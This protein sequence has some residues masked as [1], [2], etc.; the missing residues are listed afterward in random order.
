MKFKILPVI[1]F[2][3]S[4]YTLR[5]QNNYAVKGSVTDSASTGKMTNTT[6]CILNAKDSTL[7]KY[8]R[9]SNTGAFAINNLRKGNYILMVT[10]PDYADYIELFHLDSVKTQI[11]FGRI[12]MTLKS[13]IL[14]EV[15]IKGSK[16]QIKIKGDTTEFNAA[17][18]V[19]QPNSKVEDLLKQL[20]GIQVDKDG[21][22]TAQG[23]TVNKVLVDGEE[24]FGDDPTLVTKNIRAD[25]VDKVQLYDKKSDQAAFTGI[26]DGVKNKT[27]NIKL[28]EDKKTGYFGKVDA[29]IATD[30][31]YQGQL[32]FNKFTAKQKFSLYTTDANTGKTGLGWQ[33]ASKY[34]TSSDNVQMIDGGVMIMNNGRGDELEAFNGQY[35]GQGIPSARTGGLHYDTR[36]NADKE[37]LN[38]N[39]KI[40]YLGVDGTNESLSQYSLPTSTQ[41]Y[42]SAESYHKTIFRQKLD[43]TLQIKIDTAS[44]LKISIDGTIKHTQTNSDFTFSTYQDIATL[45]NQGLRTITNTGDAKIFNASAFYTKKFSK[46]GRTLSLNVTE[47]I[48]QNDTKGYL[49]SDTHYYATSGNTDSLVNQ[50]KTTV[51]NSAVLNSNLTYTEPITKTLAMVLNYGL[52]INNSTSNRESFDKSTSGEY[53]NLNTKF[54]NNF[55]LDQ[56]SNQGGLNFNYKSS[57]T[58]VNFGSKVTHVDFDQLNEYTNSSFKRS[59]LNW[60]PQANYQYNFSQRNSIRFSYSGN[61]SQPSI[62]QIQPVTNNNDPL[63]STI[64]NADLTPSFNNNLNFYYNS[65]KILSDQSV[66][67]SG[68]YSFVSNAIVNNFTNLNGKNTYQSFN[69]TDKTP[70]NFYVYSGLSEKLKKLDINVGLNLNG[71]GNISYNY[72]NKVLNTTTTYSYS[73]SLNL[74]KYKEKKFDI[75]LSF[76]PAYNVSGS[77]LT[78]N[79]NN[80]GYSLNGY[81]FMNVYLPGKI[82]IGSDGN[83][84]YRAKTQTFNQDFSKLIWNANISRKF[85]KDENLKLTLSGNDLLNQNVGFNRSANGSIISQNSY[86]SIKRYFMFSITYDFSHFGGAAKPKN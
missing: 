27:I 21:K 44:N 13:R 75:Y 25:M 83:Y 15:M 23:Q 82:E 74:S 71:N 70:S 14:A 64:G 40:G 66:Y 9:A 86:T 61:T 67:I 16:A 54:S 18:F 38:T 34:G 4:Y 46:K 11:D 28:K 19:I 63:N 60:N 59:F 47:A 1:F 29:G 52:A 43:A 77:S 84:D 20:P 69:L 78:P 68:G 57:K 8:T 80:N 62:D 7:Y 49:I 26:D 42:N 51:I 30:K 79:S 33:D 55:K 17:A 53:Q 12:N 24:F 22:I 76:G 39:Y 35:N 65:Y 45:I 10:Y 73:G 81:M 3:L 37:S 85:F 2:C 48:N 5:A 32:L 31:Y 41:N 58:T 50:Y 36:F 72:T 6:I 56:F